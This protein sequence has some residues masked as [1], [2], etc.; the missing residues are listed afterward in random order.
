MQRRFFAHKTV[1]QVRFVTFLFCFFV[2]RL[3]ENM[4]YFTIFHVFYTFFHK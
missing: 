1:K 2:D 4:K 3:A